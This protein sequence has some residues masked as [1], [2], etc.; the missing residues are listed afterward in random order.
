MSLINA[1]WISQCFIKFQNAI[2]DG[3]LKE[4]NQRRNNVSFK[5]DTEKVVLL[6]SLIKVIVELKGWKK[7]YARSLYHAP[8]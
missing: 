6:K 4:Y 8:N 5:K 1:C 2:S 7:I 3:D